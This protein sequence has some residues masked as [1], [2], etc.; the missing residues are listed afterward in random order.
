MVFGVINA[1]IKLLRQTDAIILN[2]NVMGR[3]AHACA[4]AGERD[5]T[6]EGWV[7]LYL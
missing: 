1:H 7:C 6:S 4:G 5:V 3:T 2:V